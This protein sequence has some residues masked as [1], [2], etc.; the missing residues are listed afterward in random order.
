MPSGAGTFS[1]VNITAKD[2]TSAT[3]SQTFSITISSGTNNPVT[4]TTT[5]LPNGTPGQQYGPVQITATGGSGGYVWSISSESQG[6][7]LLLSQT[8]LLTGVSPTTMGSYTL[9]VTVQDSMGSMATQAYQ[10]SVNFASLGITSG[11]P[12]NGTVNQPYFFIV[13]A[14]GGSGNYTW[15]ANGVPG[16]QIDPHAGSLSGTPTTPGTFILLVTATD[17]NTN[18]NLTGSVSYSIT[19]APAPLSITTTSLPNG[20]A[21]APYPAIT[22]IAKGGFGTFAWSATGAPPGIT[23]SSGG[24]VA[25]TPAASGTFNSFTVTVTDAT[26]K[27]TASQTYSVIIGSGPLSITSSG[28]LGGFVPGQSVSA[29]FGASGGNPPYTWSASGLP[30]GFTLNS[31]SGALAGVA[32]QPGNYSFTV[33][34]MDSQSAASSAGITANFSILGFTTTSPLPSGS[35]TTFY[36][37]N[38]LAAGGTPPYSFSASGVPAGLSMASSGFLSGTPTAPGSFS[39]SVTVTDSQGLSVSGSFALTIS[40]T[41]Q[42]VQVS[43]AALPDGTLTASYSQTLEAE[44]GKPPYSWSIIGGSLPA[45]LL[46]SSSGTI[47]GT[48]SAVGLAAFT[49][50]ATDSAGGFASAVFTIMVDPNALHLTNISLPNGIA[51]STYP[52]Q[53]IAATGGMA[54]YKSFA[55]TSGSPAGLSFSNDLTNAQI[56][57]APTSIG[58]FGFTVTATDQAGNVASGSYSLTIEPPHADL[59]L[60]QG[61]VSF[62]LATGATALPAGST[63][64]VPVLSSSTSFQQLNY[65]V[66]GSAVSWLDVAGGPATPAPVAISLDPSAINLAPGNYQTSIAVTCQAPSPCNGSMRSIAV[67]LVVT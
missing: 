12:P 28:A 41:S 4:I 15:S 45:G 51:G 42:P 57:G 1:N 22:L 31:A 37:A 61:S 8:G 3:V 21:G 32:P 43:G 16:L 47:S 53:T 64:T 66:A 54:P 56:S 25:G 65:A 11:V 63:A 19:I 62:A 6:L 49:A 26:S 59:I 14:S 17:T 10:F 27:Q 36:S 9:N 58:S 48:P 38:I 55:I 44:G 13:T 5:A 23:V 50:R 29:S 20:T 30:S 52:A 40:S 60:S 7:S 46:L 2:T 33:T 67:N 18:T 34:V 35:T 24:V 39:L